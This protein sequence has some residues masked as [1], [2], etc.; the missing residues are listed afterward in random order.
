MPPAGSRDEASMHHQSARRTGPPASKPRSASPPHDHADAAAAPGDNAI[1][2][3]PGTD[4]RM[5]THRP[6]ATAH[7]AAVL[8]SDVIVGLA[9]GAAP[10]R[11]YALVAGARSTGHRNRD[12][13]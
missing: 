10:Q 9:I 8:G 13:A 5:R 1:A 7:T 2:P 6:I 11:Q 3:A 12:M 4:S